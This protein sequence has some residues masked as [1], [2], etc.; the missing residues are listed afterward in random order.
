M[1]ISERRRPMDGRWVCDGAH[2]KKVD[3]RI[4]SIPTLHGEDLS[5]RLLERERDLRE[6]GGLGMLHQEL[7]LLNKLLNSPSGLVLVTGPTGAGKT[8]TLYACLHRLNDGQ[9]KINT[10]ED[11]IEYAIEGVRQS[12]AN[13]CLDVT[14]PSLLRSVLRQ[15]PDVILIGEMRDAVTAETAVR[16]A[17]SGH[18]V[19]ATLHSPK[20]GAAVQSMLSLGV[21]THFLASCL[22]GVVA[23]RLVRTLCDAG[24]ASYDVSEAPHIFEEVQHW[25]KPGEGKKIFGPAGC[26]ACLREGYAGQTGVF[27][28]LNVTSEIRTLIGEGRPPQVIERAAMSQGMI[29]VRQG[30]L[31]KVARGITSTEEVL[32]TVPAEYLGVDA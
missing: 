17:N 22:L 32:R 14:F 21:R 18:L 7:N 3:L 26:S 9:R 8:T 1:D 4:S 31:L 12:Q 5:L 30:T 28:V 23:Q 16:A 25:L 29:S 27:E 10:I 15:S 2:G 6:L 13:D 19:F 20:A 24:K 11:P